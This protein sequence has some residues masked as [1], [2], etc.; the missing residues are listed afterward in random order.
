MSQKAI[1]CLSLF[2]RVHGLPYVLLLKDVMTSGI[3]D[4]GNLFRSMGCGYYLRKVML[5]T[6]NMDLQNNYEN[7]LKSI[8]L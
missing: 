6:M 7:M 8:R 3:M 2:L 4:G 5:K 1:F